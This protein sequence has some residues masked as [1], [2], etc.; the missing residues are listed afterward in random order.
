MRQPVRVGPTVNASSYCEICGFPRRTQGPCAACNNQAAVGPVAKDAT[1]HEA[2]RPPRP[3]DYPDLQGA[4]GALANGDYQRMVAQ[5]LQLAGSGNALVT[6]E[7]AATCWAFMYESAAVYVIVDTAT[8]TLSIE[9]PI[10]EVP[11]TQRVAL[12]RTLL[13]L[14]DGA[15]GLARFCL[16]ANLVV[17]RYSQ[18]LQS[19]S[20]PAFVEV[21]RE[22]AISADR[23][24]DILA[25]A[26]DTVRVG[27]RAQRG[28][29]TTAF[30]G[31]SCPL[32]LLADR[33]HN[34]VASRGSDAPASAPVRIEASL[35]PRAGDHA[36]ASQSKRSERFDQ[37][38][39]DQ[40]LFDEIR[41][42]LQLSRAT[43]F[44]GAADLPRVL[45][46]RAF[47]FYVWGRFGGRYPDTIGHLLHKIGRES[48]ETLPQQRRGLLGRAQRVEGAQ[49]TLT[50]SVPRELA[51]IVQDGVRADRHAPRP[52]LSRFRGATD[53]RQHLSAVRAILD[54]HRVP[55]AMNH[56]VLLGAL[57]EFLL[58][59]LV[60]DLLAERVRAEL[61]EVAKLNP[62]NASRARLVALLNEV[63][64]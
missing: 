62:G 13:K 26:F 24:D 39:A 25:L 47:V 43:Q 42:L 8:Q 20:P 17:L 33:I 9:S 50:A 15:L 55:D 23:Y 58:R 56:Y 16:R 19:V 5:C 18:S 4:F 11:Q 35:A 49:Q 51:G 64:A 10:V 63:G 29:L 32:P 59:T 53:A 46:H 45:L 38:A 30:L 57:H 6:R 12:L 48:I 40:V 21:V 27:P 2:F 60:P 3:E 1:D 14:T 22:V 52:Q 44:S 7:G 41:A 31:T 36:S 54:E 61:D 34:S 37:Q 28:R